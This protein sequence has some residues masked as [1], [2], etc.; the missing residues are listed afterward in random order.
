MLLVIEA[1]SGVPAIDDVAA[2]AGAA[3]GTVVELVSVR[4]LMAR[5]ALFVLAGELQGSG[6]ALRLQQS[7][8]SRSTVQLFVT[9]HAGHRTVGSLQFVAESAVDFGVDV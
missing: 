3:V 8:L 5:L 4:R 9:H 6:R 7:D 2:V 1:F